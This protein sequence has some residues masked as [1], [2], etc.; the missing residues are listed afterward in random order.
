MSEEFFT[1]VTTLRARARQHIER[2]AVTKGGAARCGPA[3]PERGFGDRDRVCPALPAAPLHG[4][5]HPCAGRS[6]GVPGA[7][8]RG[9]GPRRPARRSHHAARR[10]S[11]LR[12]P[13]AARTQLLGV[14][15]RS[16]SDG[17]DSRGSRGRARRD[18][19]L[20]GDDSLHRRLRFHDTHH[21]RENPGHGER[22]RR[23]PGEPPGD[24]RPEG[25][26]R[27]RTSRCS[28]RAG[29]DP[30]E[31]HLVR[32]IHPLAAAIQVAV[33]TRLA[34]Q[35]GSCWRCSGSARR[36]QCWSCA[37]STTRSATYR[38]TTRTSATWSCT[39]GAAPTRSTTSG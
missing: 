31:P 14:R 1:D 36:F 18:R 26:S 38:S 15:G 6:R 3:P 11:R 7:R 35:S 25:P 13:G 5:G 24:A 8:R 17:H 27:R 39:S 2:G 19:Q 23:R 21:A 4:H 9:A 33:P 16:E 32:P 30:A 29:R 22:T 37:T 20:L 12:P 28:S 10:H 34:R